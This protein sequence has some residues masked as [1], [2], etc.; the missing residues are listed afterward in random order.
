MNGTAINEVSH[1]TNFLFGSFFYLCF[2]FRSIYGRFT[3]FLY[4]INLFIFVLKMEQISWLSYEL[5]WMKWWLIERKKLVDIV[6]K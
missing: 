4:L 6:M 2:E 3:E 1:T 5:L